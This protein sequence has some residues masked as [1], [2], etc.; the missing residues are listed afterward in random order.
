MKALQHVH[1]GLVHSR[2]VRVLAAHIAPWLPQSGR[3]VDIGCGDGALATAIMRLRPDVQIT[4]LD[5]LVRPTP[6]ITVTQFDGCKIPHGNGA[7]D[8]ALLVDVVHHTDS[9]SELLREARRVARTLIVKDHVL[10]GWLGGPTLRAMDW[11]GNAGHGVA[12]PYNYQTEARWREMFGTLALRVEEW[13]TDL[14]LYPWFADWCFGRQLHML[15][16]LSAEE[17]S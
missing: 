16:R 13:R 10:T 7:F 14:R 15:A 1:T 6:Q 12:L 11:V 17:A 2:R 8:T 4:G 5:V 3:V 9:P